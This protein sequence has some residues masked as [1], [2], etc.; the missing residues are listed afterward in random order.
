MIFL[1]ALEVF[2]VRVSKDIR[3]RVSV[4]REDMQ[5]MFSLARR[6]CATG[7][8][9]GLAHVE[10]LIKHIGDV[11]N[12]YVYVQARKTDASSYKIQVSV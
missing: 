8:K 9:T 1:D 11:K 12:Q 10:S 6:Y 3:V 2:V 7:C 5:R 4:D